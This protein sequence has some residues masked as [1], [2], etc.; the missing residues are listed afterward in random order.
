MLYI[1]YTFSI[2]ASNINNTLDV[3]GV[4]NLE[5][6]KVNSTLSVSDVTHLESTLSV[7]GS[8]Y[9]ANQVTV[10]GA[11]NLQNILSVTQHAYLKDQLTVDGLTVVDDNLSVT[12]VERAGESAQGT[13]TAG[14]AAFA[15]KD[16]LNTNDYALMQS[17]GTQKIHILIVR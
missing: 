9:L 7:N 14:T 6:T 2:W 8:S 13:F 11:T 1:E 12:G 16:N 3:A 4:T 17:N 10:T 5:S 15:H